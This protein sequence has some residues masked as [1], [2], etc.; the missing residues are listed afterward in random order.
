[1]TATNG[2]G[3]TL[4]IR[5]PNVHQWDVPEHDG[6]VQVSYTLFADRADGTYSGIDNTHAHLN[7]PATFMWAR[8][9]EARPIRVTFDVPEGS[10]WRVATQLVP[11]SEPT[12]FTA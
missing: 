11:S 7:M 2:A 1:V 8:R 6:S 3:D 5:R 12:T 9:T 4:A 10:G